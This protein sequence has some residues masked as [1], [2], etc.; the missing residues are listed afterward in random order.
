MHQ[1]LKCAWEEKQKKGR[2]GGMK[3][4]GRRNSEDHTLAAGLSLANDPPTNL[5][6]CT[7]H[8]HTHTHTDSY[9]DPPQS[10][11]TLF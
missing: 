3:K 6:L 11:S 9:E 8:V 10:F 2:G 4:W 5:S 7:T 1:E